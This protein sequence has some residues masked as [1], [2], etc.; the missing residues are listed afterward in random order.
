[1]TDIILEN[2][3]RRQLLGMGGKLAGALALTG[4]GLGV[5][6]TAQAAY[7]LTPTVT[8]GPYF[9]DEK[10]N[11][12][13]IRDGQLGTLL[14][15]KITVSQLN[16]DG[17]ISPLEGAQVDIWHCNADG[18]YSDVINSTDNTTTYCG[19]SF[20]RG[21]QVTDANGV[22]RFVSVFP[23]WYGGRT[24]HIHANIR[25][26]DSAGNTASEHQTQLFFKEWLIAQVY[27]SD[28][29]LARAA[30]RD[31]TNSNDTIYNSAGVSGR[32]AMIL[33]ANYKNDYVRG[34]GH[35]IVDPTDAGHTASVSTSCADGVS[36]GGGG[37]PPDGSPP[38]GTP[39]TGTLPT[40]G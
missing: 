39:P 27:A 21:Y 1:M 16:S 25:T 37:T 30:S 5:S 34:I 40:G 13:D 23:G 8:E 9:V 14:G 18:V 2:A 17:S 38:D 31:T 15:L 19:S 3:D 35:V 10:L 29:Y 7:A 12:K 26:F 4:L 20:L 22:V 24:I 32:R 6:R 28:P 36:G 33:N 11:R